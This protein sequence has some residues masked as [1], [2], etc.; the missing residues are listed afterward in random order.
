LS[1]ISRSLT[2]ALLQ[3][4]WRNL[5]SHISR[6]IHRN[7]NF[8]KNSSI[9]FCIRRDKIPHLNFPLF[10]ANFLFLFI[11][12]FSHKITSTSRLI[13]IVNDS[14]LNQ[15]KMLFSSLTHSHI[16]IVSLQCVTHREKFSFYFNSLSRRR[17]CRLGWSMRR[18]FRLNEKSLRREREKEWA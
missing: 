4:K 6:F 9:I 14:K 15:T 17:Y 3:L 11:F 1:N 13:W 12:F 10:S 16:T 8:H 5:F 18:K 2:G 7:Y